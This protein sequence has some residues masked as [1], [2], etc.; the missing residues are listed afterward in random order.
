MVS[1]PAFTYVIPEE[2]TGARE[3]NASEGSARVRADRLRHVSRF[4]LGVGALQGE[5][6]APSRN[7][8]AIAVWIKSENMRLSPAEA[9]R[10]G[11]ATLPF[12]IGL[13]AT[14]RLL[15]LGKSKHRERAE[16][17]TGQYYLLDMLGVDPQRQ[18]NGY[19]RLLI[20]SKLADIDREHA[21][22][23]LET[24]DERNIG[25][26]QRFGFE[27]VHAY[28]IRSLPVHCL[29]RRAH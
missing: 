27:L 16:F 23:Y 8:E 2:N 24:S 3:S 11:F 9:L 1:Y 14:R 28:H 6:V 17:L 25:Y 10:A 13:Q 7:I 20:E 21:R 22:C 5:I 12:T 29:L 19:G 15:N 18:S 26:Y 4:V